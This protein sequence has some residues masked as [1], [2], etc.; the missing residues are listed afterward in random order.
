MA[1]TEAENAGQII[2]RSKGSMVAAEGAKVAG[3]AGKKKLITIEAGICMKTNKT[4]TICPAK[5]RHFCITKR[6]F[7]Q[8]QTFFAEIDGFFVILERSGTN[9]ALQN[10]ETR[11]LGLGPVLERVAACNIDKHISRTR[12]EHGEY[13]SCG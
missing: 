8:E 3:G 11:V 6:H 12:H 13:S 1:Q 2:R 9:P 7:M 5:K 4:T 10:L